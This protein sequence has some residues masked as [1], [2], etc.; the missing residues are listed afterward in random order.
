MGKK[1]AGR[2]LRSANLSCPYLIAADLQ[3]SDLRGA[4]FI[5]ADLQDAD[6]GGATSPISL[7]LTMKI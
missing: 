7:F 4:D 1:L 5:G 2:D 6:L 3:K